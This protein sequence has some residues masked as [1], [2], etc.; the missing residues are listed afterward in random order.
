MIRNIVSDLGGCLFLCDFKHIAER[1]AKQSSS[2]EEKIEKMITRGKDYKDYEKG[3]ISSEIF[4]LRMKEK[5]NF[6][7]SFELFK[8]IWMEQFFSVN[9]EYAKLLIN[10]LKLDYKIYCLSNIN[11]LHWKKITNDFYEMAFFHGCFLSFK[12]KKIKPDLEI[13]KE[14]I[15]KIKDPTQ[16]FLFIDDK[17]KNLKGAKKAGMHSLLYHREKHDEFLEKMNFSLNYSI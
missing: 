10:L 8:K 11:E 7:G 2:S 13:Y 12:M 15:E 16:K 14:I 6:R 9:P 5:I 4:Y 17:E 3:I 1:L